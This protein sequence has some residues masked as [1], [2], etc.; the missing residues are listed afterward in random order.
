MAVLT[1]PV[2]DQAI[3]TSLK[4]TLREK[5]VNSIFGPPSKSKLRGV[6]S[7]PADPRLSLLRSTSKLLHLAEATQVLPLQ[8][9]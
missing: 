5:A 2:P 1:D 3:S 9:N 7:Q 8:L 4:T 6:G